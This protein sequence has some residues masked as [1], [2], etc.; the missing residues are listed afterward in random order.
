M[1]IYTLSADKVEAEVEL[2]FHFYEAN[3]ITCL[4]RRGKN[5]LN[6]WLAHTS[7]TGDRYEQLNPQK[8]CKC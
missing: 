7:H 2:V 6:E 4:Y 8:Y 3:V 5:F 1:C